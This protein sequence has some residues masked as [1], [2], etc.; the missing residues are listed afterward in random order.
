MPYPHCD[1]DICDISGK[2][3]GCGNYT[4]MF[5]KLI[6]NL[7]RKDR[8]WLSHS[9]P[10]HP[11]PPHQPNRFKRQAITD[12]D[13][14]MYSVRCRGPSSTLVFPARKCDVGSR[15]NPCSSAL[16]GVGNCGSTGGR[17]AHGM[18]LMVPREAAATAVGSAVSYL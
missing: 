2:L 1:S 8:L 15:N 16:P 12:E 5:Y 13:M 6:E 11:F 14:C 18:G 10:I 7:I 9:L 4:C 17:Q 3:L